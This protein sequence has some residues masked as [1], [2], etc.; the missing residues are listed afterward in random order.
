WEFRV[1]CSTSARSRRPVGF[2]TQAFLAPTSFPACPSYP[3]CLPSLFPPPPLAAF[4]AFL[5]PPP[6]RRRDA[7]FSHGHLGLMRATHLPVGHADLPHHGLLAAPG[8]GSPLPI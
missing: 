3:P 4:L 8:A 5:P 7:A 2:R 1:P 6:W